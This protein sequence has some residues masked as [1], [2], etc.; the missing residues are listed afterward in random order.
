VTPGLAPVTSTLTIAT[1]ATTPA[2][3]SNVTVTGTSGSLSHDTTV[4]LT[5]A[6]PAADFTMAASALL[7]A[8]V[9]AGGSATSTITVTPTY[10]FNGTVNLAC[11]G[12]TGGGTPAPT[13]SFSPSS[14]A[15][16]S[17]TATLTIR[18][19]AAHASVTTPWG[20]IFY[21]MG[22]PIGGLALLGTSFT[23]RKKRFWAFLL[24]CL[25]F[26]G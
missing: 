26:S 2:A 10:G 6:T 4:G 8:S 18:T 7:P 21:A 22:L 13:C 17:G 15:K 9:S 3:T 23:A 1:S 14:V 5:V 11:S 16:G 12:I 20:G 19:T 25:V 24:G